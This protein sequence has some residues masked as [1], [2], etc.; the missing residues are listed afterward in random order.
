MCYR[1]ELLDINSH[2]SHENSLRFYTFSKTRFN[3]ILARIPMHHKYYIFLILS[4][5]R[6]TIKRV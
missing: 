4:R 2:E 5:K 6:V 1:Q 3:I